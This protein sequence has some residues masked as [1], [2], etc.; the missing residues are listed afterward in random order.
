MLFI[1][2]FY[3]EA[4]ATSVSC[5]REK[6][7][8][9]ICLWCLFDRICCRHAEFGCGLACAPMDNREVGRA[10]TRR[11][12]KIVGSGKYQIVGG[13]RDVDEES[14]AIVA[15]SFAIEFELDDPVFC[16][17]HMGIHEPGTKDCIRRINRPSRMLEVLANVQFL[18]HFG[19]LVTA[20][21]QLLENWQSMVSNAYGINGHR[22][23]HVLHEI[24]VDA[25]YR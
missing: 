13:S 15:I 5:T 10:V 4:E 23:P 18:D 6:D 3:A 1:R 19:F 25:C 16:G 2:K 21:A 20:R 11:A 17:R 14:G 22:N 7:G 9:V 8:P 12:D 24:N